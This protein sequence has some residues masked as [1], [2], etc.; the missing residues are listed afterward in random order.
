MTFDLAVRPFPKVQ[1]HVNIGLQWH[2]ICYHNDIYVL[3]T[4]TMNSE[5]NNIDS[6]P[7]VMS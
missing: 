4:S 3:Y 5:N 1:L 6:H 7:F 2:F